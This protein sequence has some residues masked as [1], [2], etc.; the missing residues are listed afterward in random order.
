VTTAWFIATERFDRSDA[1]WQEYI[2]W[3]KI[4]ELDEVVSLDSSLYPSVL[5]DIKPEYWNHIV[6]EDFMVR[7]FTDLDFLR[8]ETSNIQRKNLLCVFRNPPTHPRE[9]LKDSSSLVMTFLTKTRGRV[10]SR[11][12]EV[13]QR[14]SPIANFQRRDFSE[15]TNGAEKHRTRYV[16]NFPTNLTPTAISGLSF[17][18]SNNCLGEVEATTHVPVTNRELSIGG[19]ALGS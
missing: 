3:S 12:V 6:N 8:S 2:A 19:C 11:I 16:S 4:P 9:F 5:P 14:Y 1:S 7:F 18:F 15:P 13:F 10:L 17:A